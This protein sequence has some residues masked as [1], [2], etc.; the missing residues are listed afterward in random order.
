MKESLEN[1]L[2][3]LS[4]AAAKIQEAA[5]GARAL[6]DSLFSKLAL[7]EEGARVAN[8]KIRAARAKLAELAEGVK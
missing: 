6:R 2:I 8:G 4:R 5:G 1:A 3:G 7:A